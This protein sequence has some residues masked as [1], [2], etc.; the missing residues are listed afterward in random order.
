[1]LGKRIYGKRLGIIGMGRIGQAVAKKSQK[2]FGISIHYH[3]RK[4][5]P[6]TYR[7]II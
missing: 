1:M 4:Q 3:N 6:I 2:V 5:L 7:R